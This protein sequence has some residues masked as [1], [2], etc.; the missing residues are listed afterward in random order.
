MPRAK[1]SAS[2]P[3]S[4]I[5]E[6]DWGTRALATCLVQPAWLTTLAF[7]DFGG[8]GGGHAAVMAQ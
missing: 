1:D 7:A 8:G 6:G 5:S 2:Q 3:A 4:H